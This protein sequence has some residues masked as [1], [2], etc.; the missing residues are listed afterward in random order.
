MGVTASVQRRRTSTAF[1]VRYVMSFTGS[2]SSEPVAP[3]IT[4]S[5]SGRSPP[6][7][8]AGFN[9]FCSTGSTFRRSATLEEPPQVHPPVKAGHLVGVAVERQRVAPA[10]PAVADAALASLAPAGVV[11]LRVHVGEE[12]VFAGRGHVP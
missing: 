9:S 3:A 7:Q 1:P 8:T 5:A 11:D 4:I 6:I 10:E 12:A 2:A